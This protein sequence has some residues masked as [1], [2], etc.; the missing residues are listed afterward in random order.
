M[1]KK[2][3]RKHTLEPYIVHPLIVAEICEEFTN[4]PDTIIA[5]ILH[6]TIEDTEA[7]YSDI[8]RKFGENVS[9]MVYFCSEKSKKTDGNRRVRKRI[10]CEHYCS[11][12]EGSKLIKIADAIHNCL[13]ISMDDPKFFEKTYLNEKINMVQSIV[14]TVQSDSPVVALGNHFMEMAENWE[15][16]KIFKSSFIGE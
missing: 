15:S 8:V 3:I 4:D 11:G 12:T 16:D 2:Q 13:G 14:N 5:A 7:T 10:D 6:D 1:H 9:N